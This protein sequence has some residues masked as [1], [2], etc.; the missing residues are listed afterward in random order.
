MS[1]QTA[2]HILDLVAVLGWSVLFLA[3]AVVF[4]ISCHQAERDDEFRERT[5][6]V[7]GRGPTQRKGRRWADR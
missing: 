3:F 6:G 7:R 1:H 5:Q 2:M 4:A